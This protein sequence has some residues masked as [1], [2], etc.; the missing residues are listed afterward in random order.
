MVVHNYRSNQCYSMG[1]NM[2]NLLKKIS[3][4]VERQQINGI[5]YEITYSATKIQELTKEAKLK[6]ILFD[7][8]GLTEEQVVNTMDKLRD[9]KL[10][11]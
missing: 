7:D 2:K 9:K 8:I 11:A 6:S 1:N 4:K 3:D 5:A 10:L